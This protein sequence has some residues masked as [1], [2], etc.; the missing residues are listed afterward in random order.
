M[1]GR[2]T[3]LTRLTPALP[4]GSRRAGRLLER[5]LLV[6]RRGW[7]VILSG[8]F[9]PLFYLVGIGFG[10][11][12]LIGNVQGPGGQAISYTAFVA[13]ALLATSAMNGA[14]YEST[15]NMFFKLKY[16]KTYDAILSTP[17]GVGDIALGEI[18]WALFRGTLYAIGFMVVML[19]LGLV[20]SPLALLAVPAALLIGFAAAGMGMTATTF[21]RKWQDFD[22]IVVVTL[23]LFLFSATFFPITAYPEPLR[24]AV[25]LTPLYRGVHLIRGLT[26]NTLDWTLLID[27]VYLLTIGGIGLNVVSRRLGKLL[28]K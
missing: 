4:F 27:V 13:P 17:L 12:A 3:T 6:Y 28:L 20:T 1:T 19:L 22:L 26:T 14:V 7:L 24:T 16:A 11:G 21:M 5:N 15:F 9:E 8:F 2:A 23:P 10:L 25:E 18:G